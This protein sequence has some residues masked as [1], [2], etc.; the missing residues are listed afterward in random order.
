[1]LICKVFGNG[2]GDVVH[3]GERECSIQRRHQKVIEETPSPF[4]SHY[5]KLRKAMCDAAVCL[6]R[7]IKYSSAGNRAAFSFPGMHKY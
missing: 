6:C 5:P 1:M 2:N 7:S 4:F 3:M